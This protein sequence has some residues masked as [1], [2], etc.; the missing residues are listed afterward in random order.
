MEKLFAFW[1][2]W[3]IPH[4]AQFQQNVYL[5][6]IRD[7]FYTIIPFLVLASFMNLVGK[8]FLDPAGILLGESGLDVHDE[9]ILEVFQ[10]TRVAFVVGN[11]ITSIFL[12]VV[13]SMKIA[14]IL[15]A[16]KGLSAF[17]SLGCILFIS[18][19]S[20]DGKMPENYFAEYGCFSAFFTSFI[21]VHT[22]A[23]LS[24]KD[25]LRIKVPDN[26]PET[27]SHNISLMPAALLTELIFLVVVIIGL[28]LYPSPED[29]SQTIFQNPSFVLFYQGFVWILW[30]IG[31]PGYGLTSIIQ[32]NAYV[33][34]Q[35]SNQLGDSAYIFTS[36]FFEASTIHVMGLIIAIIV[37]SQNE[38]WRSVSRFGFTAMIFNIPEVFIF[39]LPVVL[40]PVFL[41]PYLLAPIANV[42]I[43]YFAISWQIVPIFQE[44][45]SAS[46]PLII[47]ATISTQ[48]IMG[49]VLQIVWL[50]M[51]IFIYAPFVIVS[52]TIAV[53]NSE[54]E[55]ALN[56]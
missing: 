12:T 51:D 18:I 35:I 4:V 38:Q 56:E 7:S 40:N 17:C 9:T 2:T 29:F 5:T 31:I 19:I 47:S 22:F 23:W 36:S 21:V 1:E 44:S 13:L 14:N 6:A 55:V 28:F 30:W 48:S 54:K 24:K 16:D 39:S 10:F 27:L 49:G 46:M 42:L 50:V 8:V 26:M 11:G 25:Q 37:F 52:N 33:P 15:G 20:V 53:M 3:F 45:L 32:Q 41:V 34:A 43:G